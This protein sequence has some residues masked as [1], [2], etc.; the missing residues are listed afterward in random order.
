MDR[1]LPMRQASK[2]SEPLWR[3]MGSEPR[4]GIS[5]LM[6]FRDFPEGRFTLSRSD[7][8]RT[9][10]SSATSE[11]ARKRFRLLPADGVK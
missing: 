2:H 7:T 10:F 3:G 8:R 6:F 9:L 4:E 11:D 5:H 1:T